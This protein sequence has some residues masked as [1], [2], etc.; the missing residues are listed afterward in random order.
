MLHWLILENIKIGVAS[1]YRSSSLP[2]ANEVMHCL[3]NSSESSQGGV[4][5]GG[6]MHSEIQS[7]LKA[8]SKGHS[9]KLTNE[10]NT[11]TTGD[12][13]SLSPS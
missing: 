3:N 4:H 5:G 1:K 13:G 2:V 10:T 11:F 8:D 7:K 12:H 9:T 6:L